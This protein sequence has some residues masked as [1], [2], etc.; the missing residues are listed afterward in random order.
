[1]LGTHKDLQPGQLG[2]DIR[3]QDGRLHLFNT[4]IGLKTSAPACMSVAT[5]VKT[6]WEFV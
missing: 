5:M 4:G 6:S 1:M 3:E 2:L